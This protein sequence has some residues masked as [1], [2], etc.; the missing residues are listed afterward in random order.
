MLLDRLGRPLSDLRLSVT[1]RCNFRCPYCMPRGAPGSSSFLPKKEILSFEELTLV[2]RVFRELGVRKIRLTGGEPLLRRDLPRL[3]ER[4][5][6]LDVELALTTNGVLLPRFARELRQAGLD[7]VTVSLDAL[8]GQ[9]FQAMSDAPGFGP[10]DVLAGIEAAERAGFTVLKINCV[11]RRGVND[12]E[13]P[14]LIEHFTR[15]PHVLRFIEYMDVGTQNGWRRS[16]VLPTAELQRKLEELGELIPLPRERASDVAEEYQFRGARLG[17]I[18]SVTAPFCGSCSRARVAADGGL[19]GCL[20]GPR[21]VDLK[22][23]LRGSADSERELA[24]TIAR[25]WRA[26]ADRYSEE[27]SKQRRLPLAWGARAEMSR[28]GG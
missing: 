25:Y 21:L 13:V 8:D 2:A 10:A 1:D 20:F 7:R 28:L 3:V 24:D 19:F 26:R 27:R 22:P 5:R 12:S 4:L 14:R 16:E 11:V 6:A 9:V 23:I 17:F 15:T 18:S